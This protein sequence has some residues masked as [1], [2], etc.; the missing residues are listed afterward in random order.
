MCKYDCSEWCTLRP[1]R[2]FCFKF[3]SSLE[4]FIVKKELRRPKKDTFYF[5]PDPRKWTMDFLR[6]KTPKTVASMLQND[7]TYSIA[8][9]LSLCPNVDMPALLPPHSC[10]PCMPFFANLGK[11]WESHWLVFFFPN[12]LLTAHQI[13]TPSVPVWLLLSEDG[14]IPAKMP[15]ILL[16]LW[17]WC[18]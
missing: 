2:L 12:D 13:L 8:I 9:P 6:V 7:K 3:W 15:N 5:G 10:Q 18:F 11:V 1:W 16:Y 17:E 4:I 14:A